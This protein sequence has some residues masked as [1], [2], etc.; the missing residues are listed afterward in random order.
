MRQVLE[1][2]AGHRAPFIKAALGSLPDALSAS[3]QAVFEKTREAIVAEVRGKLGLRLANSIA[4]ALKL[5]NIKEYR[6]NH[7]QEK[8]EEAKPA[9]QASSKED[10]NDERN[11]QTHRQCP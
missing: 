5:K 10:K 3:D 2:N 6:E 4:N 8:K 7:P 1:N 9:P 11:K